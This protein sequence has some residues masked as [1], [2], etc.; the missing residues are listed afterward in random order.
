ME[1]IVYN[2]NIDV[3]Q[4][5]SGLCKQVE[6][7]TIL[8]ATNRFCRRNTVLRTGCLTFSKIYNN[9]GMQCSI[10]LKTFYLTSFVL[11]SFEVVLDCQEA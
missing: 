5:T 2:A 9:P 8:L 11:L 7:I 10:I 4:T 6:I 1:I 3:S